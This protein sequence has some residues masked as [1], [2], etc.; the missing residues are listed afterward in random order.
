[1]EQYQKSVREGSHTS[2][3]VIETVASLLDMAADDI[4]IVAMV[5]FKRDGTVSLAG[6]IP[7]SEVGEALLAGAMLDGMAT[8]SIAVLDGNEIGGIL[9]EAKPAKDDNPMTGFYL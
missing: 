7:A 8:G 3:D 6:S 1:M 5:V 2:R 4:S 9:A